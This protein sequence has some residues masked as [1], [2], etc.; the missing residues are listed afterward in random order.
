MKTLI[1]LFLIF[2]CFG[3]NAQTWKSIN[4]LD[5]YKTNPYFQFSINPYTNDIWMVGL[6]STANNQLAVIENGGDIH[7]F[8][9]TMTPAFLWDTDL[10][11]AFTPT[12]VYYVYIYNSYNNYGLYSFENYTPTVRYDFSSNSDQFTGISSNGDSIYV[13]FSPP[14][15]DLN[16]SYKIYTPSV[17]I[18]TNHFAKKIIAKN[19]Y[20]YGI[21]SYSNDL[22]Y[23]TGSNNTDYQYIIGYPS[24]GGSDPDYLGGRYNE[25]KFTRNTDTLFVAGKLG[26][27]KVYNYDVFDT[28]T[29]NNTVNMPS[30]NVLEVEWDMED[31]LWAVF[32]DA[33]D[34]PFAIAKL[35]NDTWTNYFDA[36]NSPIDF[37]S[38]KGLEI[39]TLSNVWVADW[40][41]LHTIITP[42]SPSWLGTNELELN[43]SFEVYPNPSNG[44]FTIATEE[45]QI[46]SDIEIVDLMGR[47]IHQQSFQPKV[48]LELPSGNY[49]LQLKN[50]GH[51]LGVQKIMI[52]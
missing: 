30:P 24:V 29:P 16:Y 3:N 1:A 37:T 10:S 15:F 25:I 40:K 34:E 26:I 12:N 39:D 35:E 47:T 6:G 19:S 44:S 45:I 21:Y 8:P 13:C 20:K 50:E 49:F 4:K 41:S 38:F 52:E 46:V 18:T 28:I 36:N 17:L 51:L 42:N 5:T 43:S 11:L 14:F 33:S 7:V 31:N 23:F 32:G 22:F 2:I 9:Q 27:S 48:T